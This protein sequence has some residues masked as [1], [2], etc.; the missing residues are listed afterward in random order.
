MFERAAEFALSGY[1]DTAVFIDDD[2]PEVFL[3]TERHIGF[4]EFFKLRHH[5]V[6]AVVV[7]SE[8]RKSAV[9][10]GAVQKYFLRIVSYQRYG[11][12]EVEMRHFYRPLRSAGVYERRVRFDAGDFEH[13]CHKYGLIDAVA[14][15]V[16]ESALRAVPGE[17]GH[18][19][20]FY[21][22]ISV[23]LLDIMID[24]GDLLFGVFAVFSYF[25]D[26]FLHIFGNLFDVLVEVPVEPF[27][28]FIPIFI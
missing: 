20:A 27:V 19:V 15:L 5:V 8:E 12:V 23:L 17:A 11:M 18:Q 3:D 4:Y 6:T 9:L 13:G 10:R 21:R 14:V 24:C 22:N 7:V 26:F 16:I 2:A 25:F 1:A 28:D